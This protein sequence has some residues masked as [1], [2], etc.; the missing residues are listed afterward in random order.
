MKI[1][2]TPDRSK[3]KP[4]QVYERLTVVGFVGRDKHRHLLW[5]CSCSCGG[6]KVVATQE[7]RSR[8]TRS[9]GCLERDAR[10]KHGM[11]K[12][13][14][15]R[16]W[17]GML[18]RCRNPKN[19]S[20]KNY[21]SRGITVCT[22]WNE[23]KNFFRDMGRR[24]AGLTLERKD[25]NLGYSPENCKW[26]TRKVQRANSRPISSGPAKQR[27]FVAGH[28]ATKKIFKSNNQNRFAR[29]HNLC[30][31]GISACLNEKIKKHKGWMFKWL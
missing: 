6:E 7:L 25:N 10:I 13:P 31:S 20:Y 9:C 24:P 4:D 12:T 2:R 28:I 8:R 21:G 27:R 14:E 5:L 17:I 16:I 19:K 11:A 1:L 22:Q 29:E 15:Y 30:G 18:V 23:F 3:V 26:V